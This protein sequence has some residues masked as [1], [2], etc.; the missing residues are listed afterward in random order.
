MNILMCQFGNETNTFAKGVTTFEM[1][2]PSGWTKGE[3]VI[4]KFGGTSSYLGGALQA[5]EEEGET[6]LPIDLLTNNGNF[7]A[8][9]LMS[10]EC[11]TRAMEGIC[12]GIK[13]QLGNFDGIFFALH[14]GGACELDQDLESFT[15]RQIREV[16]GPDMPIMCST[17]LHANFTPEMISLC[18]GFFPIK[19]VPHNDCK[20]AGYKAAKTLIA[21]IRGQL[22]PRMALRRL[23]LLVTSSIGSTMSGPAKTVM[24]HF[25]A[26]CE[27]HNLLDVSF[28][29]GFSSTDRPC[30]CSSVLVTADGYVPDAEADELAAFVWD[31][32]REFVAESLTAAEAIDKAMSLRKDG[33]VVVN[34]SSDNPGS[35]CP[36][37]GT[38]LLREML[39]RNQPRTI[40][41]PVYDPETAAFLH[42]HHV[43]DRVSIVLGGKTETVA[44]EPLVL[45]D[46]EII[47]LSDGKFVSAAP[48]NFGVAMDY[49]KSARCRKGNVEFIVVSIRFQVYDDR[50]FVMTGVDMTQYDLVALKSMNHFRG[51]F[52]SR[53]DAI[54]AADTPGLR[55][56]NL[57]LMNYQQ[58]IRPIFPLDDDTTYSGIWPEE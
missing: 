42:Q 55:P 29:H 7:G 13:A 41:G 38:H 53:A 32:H 27:A 8:G 6:A 35:G 19:E 18:D 10:A 16:V 9:P 11:A 36:G 44:G 1:L 54:V 21:T 43:G 57:K 4:A 45:D 34:E 12:A 58:V 17:D 47:N 24:D 28:L 33:Y 23:P 40:M 26:Y 22:K 15:L 20:K 52:A 39:R 51:Y 25:A 48:I 14:G 49:G 5:I 56:A 31:M 2:V 46:V 30:S 37:D 50:S 3:D